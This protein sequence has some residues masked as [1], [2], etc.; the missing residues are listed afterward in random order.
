M[1]KITIEKERII[2]ILSIANEVVPIKQITSILANVYLSVQKLRLTVRSTN[3]NIGF[4]TTLNIEEGQ[5]GSILILCDKLINAI[6]NLPDAPV[7]IEQIDESIVKVYSTTQKNIEYTLYITNETYPEFDSAPQD[8]YSLI[9]QAEFKSMI[10]KTIFAVSQDESRRNIS[11]L[12]LETKDSQVMM[13]GTDGR[14]LFVH[15]VT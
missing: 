15:E 11:G 14:R 13:V 6:K 4:E 10:H 8:G 2:E 12:F 3:L 5:D 7:T 9:S 1:L